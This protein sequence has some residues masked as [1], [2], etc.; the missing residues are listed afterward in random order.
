MKSIYICLSLAY[1]SFVMATAIPRQTCDLSECERQCS[2][3]GQE[4][5]GADCWGAAPVCYCV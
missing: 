5:G 3:K 1:A 4:V 2:A